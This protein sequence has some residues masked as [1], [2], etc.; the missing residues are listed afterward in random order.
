MALRRIY[1]AL[2]SKGLVVVWTRE[3]DRAEARDT[4]RAGGREMGRRK[5]ILVQL[6]G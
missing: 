5:D 2:G 1:G 3:E 4:K 6:M